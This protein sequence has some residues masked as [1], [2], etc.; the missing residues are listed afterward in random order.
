M[1]IRNLRI[2]F[3]HYPGQVYAL[4][5]RCCHGARMTLPAVLVARRANMTADC[6]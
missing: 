6:V 4:P 3:T 2:Y 5:A 1:Y